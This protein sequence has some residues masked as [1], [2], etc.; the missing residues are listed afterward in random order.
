MACLAQA[1]SL[2]NATC[3]EFWDEFNKQA[4]ESIGGPA[5]PIMLDIKNLWDYEYA[6]F[7]KAHPNLVS[8]KLDG[9]NTGQGS[10]FVM[11]VYMACE[12]RPE[13]LPQKVHDQM[14]KSMLR[15]SIQE[16][17]ESIAQKNGCTFLG[18][19]DMRDFDPKSEGVF[20][21]CVEANFGSGKITAEKDSQGK[22]SK[23]KVC[24]SP[25]GPN[26]PQECQF[27]EP[28]RENVCLNSFGDCTKNSEGKCGWVHT[29]QSKNCM[30]GQ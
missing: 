27:V 11:F 14:Q 21:A 18:E 22:S 9:L 7:K 6:E 2:S 30:A 10:F 25:N 12:M 16:K 1:P 15:L 3:Q 17:Q 24:I 8:E 5:P 23:T 13:N 20:A 4:K 29:E 19:S 26:G 28:T